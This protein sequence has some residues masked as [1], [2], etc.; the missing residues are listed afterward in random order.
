MFIN[1]LNTQFFNDKEHPSKIDALLKA[2]IK[3]AV[4]LIN[5][6]LIRHPLACICVL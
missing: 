6:V 4:P 3:N 1:Q 5:L 2:I